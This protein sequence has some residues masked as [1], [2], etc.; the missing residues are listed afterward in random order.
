[1]CGRLSIA[2]LDV[3]TLQRHFGLA[4]QAPFVPRYNLPPSVAIPAIRLVD[5]VRVLDLLRW[6]LV[7]PWSKERQ[8]PYST[9]NARIETIGE[10]PAYREAFRRRRCLVPI[11]G[12]YEWRQQGGRKSPYY[13]RAA[14]G[15]PLACAGV[16]ERWTDQETGEVL[17]SCA[18]VTRPATGPM[19]AIHDRMP[20]L[21]SGADFEA[22]LDPDFDHPLALEAMLQTEVDLSIHAVGPYVNNARH[23]GAECLVEA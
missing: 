8:P 4:R 13:I 5:G 18:I 19:L 16:W 20:A 2:F 12:F 7:P 22:W 10:K 21:V 15:A 23:D 3:G 11:S 17:L 1:M 9:F 14:D 6:G